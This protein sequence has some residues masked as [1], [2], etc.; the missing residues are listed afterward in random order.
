MSCLSVAVTALFVSHLFPVRGSP[1]EYTVETVPKG[2]CTATVAEITPGPHAFD[3]GSPG[4]SAQ[5]LLISVANTGWAP[6]RT[7]WTISLVNP[8][9]D[10][11]TGLS[12]LVL[13]TDVEYGYATSFRPLQSRLRGQAASV[14]DIELT[15]QDRLLNVLR[16]RRS[17]AAAC[18]SHH[19]RRQCSKLRHLS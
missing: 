3:A 6:V 13:A 7:P 16:I 1:Q 19:I 18:C 11:A 4:S 10:S 9:Y 17:P 15:E 12:G 14:L 2:N 5:K 8:A